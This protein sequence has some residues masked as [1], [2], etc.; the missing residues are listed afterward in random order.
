MIKI[1]LLGFGTVGQGVYE[2]IE[3][4]KT[5]LKNML[6]DDIEIKK[7][8]IKNI[9]KKR[10]L[11]IPFCKFSLDSKEI[12]E[13]EEISIIVELTG[14]VDF[15]YNLI[16]EA[17]KKN[18]N[19][20]TANK[21][22]VSKYFE[23]LSQLAQDKNLFFMYEASVGGA[24]PIV[25]TLKDQ[26]RINQIKKIKGI[27]NGTCNY[28]LSKMTDEGIS[29]E[30]ALR[31]AQ[32]LGYAEID[33]SSDVEGLDTMRK[34]RILSS[35]AF[36]GKV[37]EEDILCSGISSILPKDIE[38]L[39]NRGL[40]LKLVGESE[41]SDNGYKSMVETRAFP[42]NS[43]FANTKN[44]ENIIEITCKYPSNLSLKGLGAGRYPTANAVVM[45]ILDIV[46][47]GQDGKISL[48]KNDLKNLNERVE[49]RYYI[50][51]SNNQ[52]KF[53]REYIEKI[54]VD[55]EDFYAFI[56]KRV[57]FYD[58]IKKLGNLPNKDFIL[59]SIED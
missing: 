28:I 35:I 46:I 14:D 4:R 3:D 48:G 37:G 43:D 39:K 13:D 57:K 59:I 15:S 31:E 11:E 51:V 40:V 6:K 2:I 7:V 53:P 27:L 52:V 49:G 58:L 18:K 26:A 45:D 20:V 22:L 12:L 55:D 32:K 29:Y 9:Q 23:E 54:I 8:L 21:A 1:A 19:V 36:K 24:I 17:F 50:R 42:I 44:A 10:E 47:A 41:I 56:S 5:D 33:P 34:L 16:K 25:K 30:E 38:I